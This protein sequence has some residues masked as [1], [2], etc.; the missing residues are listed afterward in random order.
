MISRCLY[1]HID[2]YVRHVCPFDRIRLPGGHKPIEQYSYS[3]LFCSE[4]LKFAA[5]F[6]SESN[7]SQ[8]QGRRILELQ[9]GIITT[10]PFYWPSFLRM[11]IT[12]HLQ[13]LHEFTSHHCIGYTSSQRSYTPTEE[14]YSHRMASGNCTARKGTV[15]LR[16]CS[17][18]TVASTADHF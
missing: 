17:L 18:V 14:F 4:V 2:K 11:V 16:C 10:L 3:L 12:R 6:R 9:T 7:T 15:G 1:F 13:L 5:K 8:W